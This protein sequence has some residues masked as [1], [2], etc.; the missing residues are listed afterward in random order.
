MGGIRSVRTAGEILQRVGLEV[1]IQ[2]LGITSGSTAKASAFEQFSVRYFE[3][4]GSLID[5]VGL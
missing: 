4:W 2:P 3:D 5:G 1:N